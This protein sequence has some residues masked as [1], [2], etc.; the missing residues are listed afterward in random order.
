MQK[1]FKRTL[2]LSPK[3]KTNLEVFVGWMLTSLQ[4]YILGLYDQ[5]YTKFIV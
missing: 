2:A 5:L 1:V 3:L 4:K